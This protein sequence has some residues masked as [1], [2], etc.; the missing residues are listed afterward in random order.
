MYLSKVM[1]APTLE[2]RACF[3]DITHNSEYAVHQWLWKLFP[4]QQQRSFLYREMIDAEGKPVYWVLSND[5]PNTEFPGFRVMSKTLAPVL[6]VGMRLSFSLRANPTKMYAG[7]CKRHDVLMDAKQQAKAAG[8]SLEEIDQKM[9][10]AALNWLKERGEQWGIKFGDDLALISVEQKKIR[11]HKRTPI[12]YTSV[13]YQGS[14]EVVNPEH[15]LKQYSA[16]FGK[17][18]AFGCGLM[19]IKPL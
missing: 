2:G 19:L 13:D 4:N 7:T 12:C 3:L 6:K 17:A 8:C 9:R 18:K 1:F 15:F 10:E 5:K 11:K 14:F 16:G